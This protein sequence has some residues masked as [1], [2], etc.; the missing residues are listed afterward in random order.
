VVAALLVPAQLIQASSTWMTTQTPLP[1]Y[2]G[3]TAGTTAPCPSPNTSES[4]IYAIGGYHS[5][6]LTTVYSLAPGA[7]AW[8]TTA[9]ALPAGRSFPAAA[10]GTD[11]TLYAL[12]GVGD[13]CTGGN[14][15]SVS[16]STVYSYKPGT[17]TQWQTAPSLPQPLDAL[18]ATTAPCPAPNTSKSCIYA[19]GGENGID[20]PQST[21]YSLAPGAS[22]WQ[23]TAPALPAALDVLAAATG[24]DGTIYAIGGESC[25][26]MSGF[27]LCTRQSTVYTFNPG[28]DTQWQTMANGLPDARSDL[29]ATTGTDGTI[30]A[31]G[32]RD[33]SNTAQSTVYSLAP[34]ASAWQTMASGLPDVR[35]YLAA[36]TGSDGTLYAFGGD[37]GTSEPTAVY[38][39]MPDTTVPTTTISLSPAQPTGNN[40]WYTS[41]V[42]VSVSATDPDDAASTLTTRCVLDPATKPA[43]F[44]DLPSGSCPYAVSGGGSV[45][46]DRVHT[47]YAASEDPAGNAEATVQSATF[48]ID[49]TGPSITDQTDSCSQPGNN[50][51]C[52][53]TET[54]TFGYSDATSGLAAP[55]SAAPGVTCTQG[56]SSTGDG[57]AVTLSSGSATDV[58]GNTAAAITSGPFQI[59]ATPPTVTCQSPAPSFVLGQ[60]GAT[61]SATV[62]D[63]T[64]GPAQTSISVLAPTSSVGSFSVSLTG[65]DKAG[66]NTTQSCPY[67]VTKA[68]LTITASSATILPGHIIPAITPSYSGFLPGDSPSSLTTLPTC[69]TTATPSSSPGFYTTSCSGA[70]DPDYHFIYDPGT[71]AIEQTASSPGDLTCSAKAI[72]TGIVGGDLIVDGTVCRVGHVHVT[73]DVIVK[74]GGSLLGDVVAGRNLQALGATQ[75]SLTGGDVG[76]DAILQATTAGPDTFDGVWVGRDLT[77][78]SNGAGATWQIRNDV[79]MGSALIANNLGGIDFE[80]NRVSRTVGIQGNQGGVTVLLN[81]YS[82]LTCTADAPAATGQ[83]TG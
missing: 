32:G 18:A 46:T 80:A 59:D 74:N 48:K 65:Y 67:A 75:I 29:A 20:N 1:R 38:S 58:A 55:C 63:A 4:C 62:S 50:G 78:Q 42:T 35:Y 57:A 51:W 82:S 81:H 10:T 36:A 37:T 44:A 66:N 13:S 30:Y 54:S 52:S 43:S 22:A 27:T 64:S 73:R 33:S 69:G 24:K 34:G 77:I 61:V 5:G 72:L 71:L 6:P 23:T 26:T 56:V 49:Q 16:E 21:V 79:V 2:V 68:Q 60:A 3:A 25:T 39:L 53:G 19:I 14:C 17:D 11:G 15:Q 70:V 8:D 28:T 9:P 41:P 83:C 31:I 45:S 12:G 47:I 7:S 40:G 76:Q